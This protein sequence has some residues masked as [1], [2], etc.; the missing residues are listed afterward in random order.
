MRR[1]LRVAALALLA[2][3]LLGMAYGLLQSQRR[4]S[5]EP[6]ADL[7]LPEAA[8]GPGFRVRFS[9]VSTLLFDDGETAWMT[10]GFFSRPGLAATAFTRIAPDAAA[11][12]RGLRRLGVTRLA[13]VVPVH[14]HYDH[15]LDAPLVA[16]RTGALLVGSASTLNIG[17]GL[18]LAEDRMRE[19][20]PGDTLQF[21]RFRLTFLASRHSPTPWSDGETVEDISA[22]LH[23]PA[24][25]SAWREGRVWSLLVEHAGGQ[26][27]L[28][29]GSAGYVAGALAGRHADTVLLGVGTL[30]RKSEAYRAAYWREVVQ[31]V[32]AKRVVPV[33]WD[34]FS[35]PLELP[36]VALPWLL[37]D[38]EVTMADL[39]A[40]GA[41][42]GVEVRMPPS[43]VPFRP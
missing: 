19:V 42:A 38:V 30:G 23:P 37:D 27:V 39:Q 13:A 2:L 8:A 7:T 6:Y 12:D 9:G 11:V 34:D 1:Q 32:G 29:Q 17:R 24:H 25:A 3:L 18:G 35:R 26:S 31:A 10:D 43:I 22:P 15:A 14:S 28:V 36:L 40:R 20:Q 33:H 16:Q 41:R 4:P 21:G 5:L